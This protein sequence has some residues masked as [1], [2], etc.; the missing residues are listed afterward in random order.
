MLKQRVL[1][2]G[3]GCAKVC[4][5]ISQVKW[6]LEEGHAAITEADEFGNTALLAACAG[7]HSVPGAEPTV[8]YL[9]EYGGASMAEETDAGTN[10]WDSLKRP[11]AWLFYD[12]PMVNPMLRVFV[13]HGPPPAGLEN[14]LSF[15]EHRVLKEV[16]TRKRFLLLSLRARSRVSKTYLT[17]GCPAASAA[18]CVS[19]PAVG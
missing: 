12:A 19:I 5:A 15:E 14:R 10:A 4:H 3:S 2:E 17:I 16:D 8:R 9:L 13:L 1:G 11:F 7:L 6:L 18:S